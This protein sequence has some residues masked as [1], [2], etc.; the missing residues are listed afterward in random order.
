MSNRLLIVTTISLLLFLTGCASPTKMAFHD[1]TDQALKTGNP[2][3]LMTTT[4]KSA[5]RE[6]HQPKLRVVHVEKAIVKGKKD[7]FNFVMDD[8]AKNE[9]DDPSIGSEYLLRMELSKGDY[10]LR[11][12]SSQ[13]SSF[14]IHGFFFTPIH[15]DIKATESGVFYLGHIDATVR[16]RVGNEFKA[17]SSIPLIDQAIAGASGGTFDIEITDQWDIDKEKF[18]NKFP[19]LSGV[20]I[21]KTILPPFNKERA[22]TW[23]EKN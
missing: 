20:E 22:Q 19:A 3:Y 16:E 6:S 9:S 12:L 8:K 14:P 7:R 23:W 5:Y 13:S 17:G 11:G 18:L 15:E 2:I 1:G 4:I 21:K 10:V